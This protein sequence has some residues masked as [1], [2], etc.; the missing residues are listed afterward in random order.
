MTYRILLV[1]CG[2][3]GSRHLQA[4]LKI[5]YNLKIDIIEPKNSSK[6][7]AL[8]R[9]QE[10][11]YNNKTKIINWHNCYTSKI[12]HSDLVIVATLSKNRANLLIKLINNGH[13]RILSEKILCQSKNEYEKIIKICKDKQAKI[14]VNTTP[15]CFNSFIKLKKLLSN[16]KPINLTVYSN[17]KIGLGTTIIH[18]LDLFSWMNDD[19]DVT[20]DGTLLNKLLPNK[21]GKDLVEFSGTVTGNLKNNAIFVISFLEHYSDNVIVKL[22]NNLDEFYIDETNQKMIHIKDNTCKLNKFTYEHASSLTTN[23]AIDIIKNDYCK[24]PTILESYSP[25]LEIF[26]VFNTHINN[27]LKRNITLC[28]IT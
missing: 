28:P 11:S 21:R 14:W 17:P 24:L 5:P 26:R 12:L 6:K 25:H 8:S 22:S 1:G 7:L 19:Y 23:I 3:V 13:K 15:R 2:N 18:F 27:I 20:L 16:N 10:I 9:L 4:L